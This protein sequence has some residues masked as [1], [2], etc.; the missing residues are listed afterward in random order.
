[1]PIPEK[2]LKFICCPKCKGDL[3]FDPVTD[4]LICKGC[5]ARYPIKEG[6]PI[7]VVEE[8]EPLDKSPDSN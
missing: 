5:K 3:E 7:L 6:I 4:S 1:M 8:A 2:L